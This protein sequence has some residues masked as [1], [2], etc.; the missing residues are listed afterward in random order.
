MSVTVQV[1]SYH[2]IYI[3]RL[4]NILIK[5]ASVNGFNSTDTEIFK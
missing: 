5:K 3:D 4:W 1:W 2:I